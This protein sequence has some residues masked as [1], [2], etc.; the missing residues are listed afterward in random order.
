MLIEALEAEAADYI[1]RHRDQR[2][3]AGRALVVHNG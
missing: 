1:E 2:D 3:A